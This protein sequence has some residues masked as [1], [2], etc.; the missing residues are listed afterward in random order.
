[1]HKP[2]WQNLAT[3]FHFVSAHD[4]L[5]MQKMERHQTIRDNVQWLKEEKPLALIF[6]SHR[7][8]TLQHPDPNDQQL[9]ALQTFFNQVC[10][11]I[12]AM[13]VDK[14]ERLQLVPSIMKE[15]KWRG[16]W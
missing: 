11:C 8:E 10:L 12:E 14:E 9:R 15:E 1:M 4:L 13:F 3:S 6:V 16:V 5:S 2:D 7:W